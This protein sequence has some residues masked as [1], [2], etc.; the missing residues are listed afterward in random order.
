MPY[1]ITWYIP[2]EIVYV[3]YYGVTTT[4]DLRESLQNT[5]QMIESSPRHL[6][7]II[8]DVGDITKAVPLAESVKIVREIGGH[9]RTG[10][11]ISIRDNSALLKMGSALGSSLFRLR[12]RAFDT[13]DEA[14]AHLKWYDD[15]L[16]WDK[17]EDQAHKQSGG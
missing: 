12:F 11:T 8:S 2:D 5:Y 1:S 13:F 15:A 4:D 9:P 3:R 7:H 6:V 16:S 14:L 17:A 10:W